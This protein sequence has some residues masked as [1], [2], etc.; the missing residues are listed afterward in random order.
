MTLK[1]L[2]EEIRRRCTTS[3]PPEPCW[4]S[5]AACMKC[6]H[7]P[8]CFVSHQTN[9]GTHHLPSL[10][11]SKNVFVLDGLGVPQRPK[12]LDLLVEC[13]NCGAEQVTVRLKKLETGASVST[14]AAQPAPPQS[15][16]C[17]SV[18][19]CVRCRHGMPEWKPKEW[20]TR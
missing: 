14:V 17:K 1:A 3:H 7:S 10:H 5:A 9:R 13:A 16:S 20:P 6:G 15:C 11:G 19:G 18:A 12:P 8:V 4:V 2:A